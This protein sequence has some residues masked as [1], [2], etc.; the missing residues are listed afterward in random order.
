MRKLFVDMDG[1]IA[2]WHQGMTLHDLCAPGYFANLEPMQNM[3]AA[4][5][6]MMGYGYPVFIVSAVLQGCDAE[7]DKN[8]WLNRHLNIPW[9]NRFFVP[10]GESKTDV[11][12]R[13][14]SSGDIMLDDYSTN[15][16]EIVA[17]GIDMIPVKVMNGINGTKGT[18]TGARIDASLSPFLIRDQLFSIWMQ[19][20][21]K[22]A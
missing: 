10:Y 6:M 21:E 14:A 5:K 17:S 13:F 3:T 11:L 1:T 8:I 2:T 22:A 9:C 19:E 15:L 16:H 4:L 7:K 20:S 12:R 18:W